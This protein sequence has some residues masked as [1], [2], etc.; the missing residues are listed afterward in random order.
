MFDALE[1]SHAV[2]D[3]LAAVEPKIR[4]RRKSLADQI[5]RAAES[6]CLNIADYHISPLG[7][8]GIGEIGITGAAAAVANAVY[9]ATGKRVR[10]FP[11]TVDKLMA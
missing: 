6:V 11:I 9:N 1:M 10:D 8:R 5:G 7:A 4:L 3:Q 2:M